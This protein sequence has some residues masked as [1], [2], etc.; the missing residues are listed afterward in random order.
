MP[1]CIQ[2]N[3]QKNQNFSIN[4]SP[5]PLKGR[6]NG[7]G[8]HTNYSTENMRNGT[9]NK[10]GFNGIRPDKEKVAILSG[11]IKFFEKRI[12][13]NENLSYFTN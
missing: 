9:D 12:E 13:S 1:A 8:C 2:V 4:L 10:T 3:G 11:K 5:K 6:W 7:S